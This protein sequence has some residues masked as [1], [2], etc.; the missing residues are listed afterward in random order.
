MLDAPVR[1]PEFYLVA[2]ERSQSRTLPCDPDAVAVARRLVVAVLAR[3]EMPEDAAERAEVVVSELATNAIRHARMRAGS[4]RVTVTRAGDDRVQVAV[5]DLDP[6]PLV[7]RQA[8]PYD[9]GGRG[10]DLV[11]GLSARWGCDYRRWGKRVWAEL[12]V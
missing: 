9:E 10:L 6:R 4:I 7:R 5:T 1:R 8:G 2:G 12:A 11:A 3:W